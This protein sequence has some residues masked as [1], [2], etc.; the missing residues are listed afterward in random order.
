MYYLCSRV[1]ELGY[2]LEFICTASLITAIIP[3]AIFWQIVSEVGNDVIIGL[4]RIGRSFSLCRMFLPI[5]ALYLAELGIM[6]LEKVNLIKPNQKQGSAPAFC[7]YY[8]H[9]FFNLKYYKHNIEIV[10]RFLYNIS[11]KIFLGRSVLFMKP[12]FT[13]SADTHKYMLDGIRFVCE[14]F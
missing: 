8:L 10:S 3:I 1:K 2:P 5:C 14:N 4:T 12:T 7:F 13:A 9:K 6:P 11:V